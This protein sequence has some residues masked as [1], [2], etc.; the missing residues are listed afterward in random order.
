MKVCTL[1]LYTSH[2]GRR[3]WLS[4]IVA[5]S[6]TR[7]LITREYQ[8]SPTSQD[9][10]KTPTSRH[11]AVIDFM[12]VK[13]SSSGRFVAQCYIHKDFVTWVYIEPA[14]VSKTKDVVIF[15]IDECD[16]YG[17][18]THYKGKYGIDSR[19]GRGR[20]CLSTHTFALG[21]HNTEFL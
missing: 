14:L 9:L 3:V 11:S 12:Q 10:T 6:T 4:Y 1:G 21:K 18:W 17:V 2:V 8:T 19:K 20:L 5:K 13:K 15:H 16:Y 7:V